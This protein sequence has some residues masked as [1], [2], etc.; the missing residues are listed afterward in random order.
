MSDVSHPDPTENG[1]QK[2]ASLADGTLGGYF[3]HHNRPPAFEGLDGCP[4][5]VSLEVEKTPNLLAP[6]SGYLV[7]PR[8]AETGAGIVGHLE[9]PLLSHGRSREEVMADLEALTLVEVNRHLREAIVRR[10]Q[11]TE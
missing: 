2:A 1:P 3:G 8:W 7:F 5:T 6:F 9:T 10:Q 4:Y 11:E